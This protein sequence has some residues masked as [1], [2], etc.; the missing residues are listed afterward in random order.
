[1]LVSRVLFE[2]KEQFVYDLKQNKSA[3]EQ[4]ME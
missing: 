3:F 4:G 1:M 2:T